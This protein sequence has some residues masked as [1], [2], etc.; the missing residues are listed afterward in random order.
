MIESFVEDAAFKA[1][2][3]VIVIGASTSDG[4]SVAEESLA[5]FGIQNAT[6]TIDSE[7]DG[8]PQENIDDMTDSVRVTVSVP[9]DDNM[10]ISRFVT[11]AVIERTAVMSTERFRT[12]N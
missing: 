4:G 11:G 10:L 8:V 9:M 12:L 2:R 3:H 5:V 1:A 6:I 7:A